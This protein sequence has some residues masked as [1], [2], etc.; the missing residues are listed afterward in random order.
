MPGST[1]QWRFWRAL[2]K[3]ESIGNFQSRNEYSSS[4]YLCYH[5]AP[6]HIHSVREGS[7]HW[8]SI[9]GTPAVMKVFFKIWPENIKKAII[10]L[11]ALIFKLNML[12]ETCISS[13]SIM[14]LTKTIFPDSANDCHLH[15]WAKSDW[16]YVGKKKMHHPTTA[17]VTVAWVLPLLLFWKPCQYHNS[18]QGLS[19]EHVFHLAWEN[20]LLQQPTLAALPLQRPLQ[21]CSYLRVQYTML[22]LNLKQPA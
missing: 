16:F 22:V 7:R 10:T 3:N 11:Q 9:R 4:A 2:T 12:N 19:V 21:G 8:C 5:L 20:H 15:W 14:Q 18:C 1:A 6:G 13:K 17:G